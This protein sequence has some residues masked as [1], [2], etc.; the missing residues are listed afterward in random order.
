MKQVSIAVYLALLIVIG[1]AANTFAQQREISFGHLVL[2]PTLSV[3]RVYDDN[4]YFGNGRNNT[5]E[6][7]E[8][9]WI[10]HF[11]PGLL[12]DYTLDG[13]RGSVKFGYDGDFARYAKNS[14]NDWR[15]NHLL[16]DLDYLAPGGLIAK[17]KNTF[18]DS[19]D[20]YGSLNLYA[21]GRKIKRWTDGCAGTLGYKFSDRFKIL[22]FYNFYK[23]RYANRL[24]FT[25][26]YYEA[27][28]GVGSEIK[29]ADKTWLFLRCYTGDRDYTTHLA[30]VTASNDA[31]YEW[32]KVTTGLSWDSEARFEGEFNIG[33]QWYSFD[34][35][36]DKS[37]KPYKDTSC[38]IADTS[39][40]FQQSE[41]RSFRLTFTRNLQQLQA[42][43]NGYFISSAI[44]VG[45]QQKI[46]SRFLLMAELGYGKNKYNSQ[47]SVYKGRND[48]MPL[49]TASLKYLLSDWMALGIGFNHIKNGSNNVVNDYRV[50]WLSVSLD[51]NPAYL[52]RRPAED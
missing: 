3:E 35:N 14:F 36:Q 25:Q 13:S 42:G 46:K 47:Y 40:G 27:E 52:K 12:L 32:K 5:T 48:K 31:S 28:T 34:N 24:D 19:E 37:L 10:N 11:K 50:N 44:G 43:Q 49:A 7:K 23:Q 21:L 18:V 6:L 1:T 4:I 22:T 20:P 8:S 38:L 9:D 2:L 41:T 30:M 39:V 16:F 29:V 26:N 51:L 45:V 17:I 15:R 33:Y